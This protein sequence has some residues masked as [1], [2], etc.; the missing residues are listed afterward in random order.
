[1]LIEGIAGA[2]SGLVGSIVTAVTNYKTQK[3]KNEHDVT[4]AKI[5]KESMLAEAK[6]GMQVTKQQIEGELEKADADIYEEN[7]KLGNS[8]A[9]SSAAIEKLLEGKKTKWIGAFII[10]LLGMADAMRSAMRPLLTVYLVGITS[11]ITFE[12]S[13]ILTAKQ[14]L[15]SAAMAAGI[16]TNVTNIVIFLTVSAVTFWF[17][18][19]SIE[20]YMKNMK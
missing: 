17:G 10:F 2:I 4:M 13:S 7:V 19:R 18:N 9:I 11:W 20:K 15:I 8:R 16:F 1:M 5:Q 12:A 6:I 14:A 3:L